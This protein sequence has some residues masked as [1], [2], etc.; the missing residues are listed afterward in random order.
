MGRAKSVKGLGEGA[1]HKVNRHV[2]KLQVKVV[3][4]RQAHPLRYAAL[5]PAPY[6][7]HTAAGGTSPNSALCG[8]IHTCARKTRVGLGKG[9]WRGRSFALGVVD[10]VLFQLGGGGEE[11][12]VLCFLR[13]GGGGEGELFDCFLFGRRRG[14]R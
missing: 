3:R 6:T 9:W 2:P 14:G 1:A 5:N 7:R 13:G 12:V 8:T 10:S 4:M 11:E